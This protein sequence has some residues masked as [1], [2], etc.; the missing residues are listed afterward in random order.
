MIR[1][2]RP[3][4]AVSAS[5]NVRRRSGLRR[6]DSRPS[7][8]RAERPR[9]AR[10][11]PERAPAEVPEPLRP[12]AEVPCAQPS[13]CSPGAAPR[14][15]LRE[16]SFPPRT[17]RWP[18]PAG[19]VAR[20][21]GA[22][23]PR[24]L[25]AGGRSRAARAEARGRPPG[26]RPSLVE[27]GEDPP[28]NRLRALLRPSHPIPHR[29]RPLLR[30][31]DHVVDRLLCPVAGELGRSDG[32][33]HG[34][35]HRVADGVRKLARLGAALGHRAS[36]L[37]YG[38]PIATTAAIHMNPAA[39]L[40]ERVLLP[41]DPHRALAMAQ[42][43]LEAPV[44]FNHNRGLWGYTGVAPD[45]DLLTVQATGM[46]GPS[47]AVVVEELLDL[48]AA[49]LVRVGTC[50]AFADG[51]R[52]WRS[53]GGECR[54]QRGRSERR[55][56]RQRPGGGR[57]ASD[58]ARSSTR[59]AG[60]TRARASSPRPTSSTTTERSCA[61]DWIGGRR[62]RRRDG[63]RHD[64][65]R[66]PSGAAPRPAACWPSPTSCLGATPVQGAPGWSGTRSRCG[67][68]GGPGGA[69]C[70]VGLRPAGDEPGGH[71]GVRDR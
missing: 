51:A 36:S 64:L 63:G 67:S 10:L 40:A 59:A 35:L 1:T 20:P 26:R 48:G 34:P 5:R 4:T 23:A 15:L 68:P 42:S 47:A 66:S 24:S 19:A 14:L 41:G 54:P 38:P 18:L 69:R 49:T 27:H 8:R 56:R 28:A 53:G 11:A 61:A 45:G 39:E 70:V 71:E 33:L 22:A 9:L 6:S 13:P 32:R 58:R 25:R 60:S 50:G 21:T 46:G 57:R 65:Q 37:P 17:V 29:T 44:M 16:P 7:A 12:L 2:R 52:P 31:P 30:A 3:D 62:D 43:L 55:A